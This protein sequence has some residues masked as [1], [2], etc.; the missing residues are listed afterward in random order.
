MSAN[1]TLSEWHVALT[2]TATTT[3]TGQQPSQR[4]RQKHEERERARER[5]RGKEREMGCDGASGDLKQSMTR[6]ATRTPP[7]EPFISKTMAVH[8]HS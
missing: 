3:A 7:K 5:E 4:Q 8:V 2:L 6:T 1:E